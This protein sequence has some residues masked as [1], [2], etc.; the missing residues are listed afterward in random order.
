MI[1]IRRSDHFDGRRFSNPTGA[2]GQ[3]VW[4]VPRLLL[5]P[6]TRWPSRV[7]VELRQRGG[8]G[9]LPGASGEE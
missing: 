6:R 9:R 1:A 2:N 4:M 7:P 8:F 5:A 3:P